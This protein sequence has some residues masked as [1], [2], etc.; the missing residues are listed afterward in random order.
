MLQEAELTLRKSQGL[1]GMEL[2]P[3]SE[4]IGAILPEDKANTAVNNCRAMQWNPKNESRHYAPFPRP[5]P[6]RVLFNKT[7]IGN[8]TYFLTV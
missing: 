6:R 3:S 4:A 2:M 7:T 1:K 8:V 5:K